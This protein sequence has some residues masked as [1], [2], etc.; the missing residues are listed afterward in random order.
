MMWQ[1]LIQGIIIGYC[2]HALVTWAE[3][4]K[5]PQKM[6]GVLPRA[7]GLQ[8]FSM[9]DRSKTSNTWSNE[10]NDIMGR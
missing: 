4:R 2:L 10:V 3:R 1:W 8:W 6:T 7:N 5:K 9:Q